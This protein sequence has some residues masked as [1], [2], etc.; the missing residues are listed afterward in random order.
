VPVITSWGRWPRYQQRLIALADRFAPPPDAASM[1]A[2]GNGRSYGDVCL[3]EGGT[4]LMT[5]ALDRFI[6]LDP[7][8]GIVECEAGTLLSEI[9]ELALPQGWFPPVSPGTALVTVGGAIANDVH[10]KN[11]HRTGSFGHHVLEFELQRSD[12]QILRCARDHHAQWFRATIGGLGLTGLIRK[13]RL[14][15]R[16]VAGPWMVGDSRRFNSLA[17]FFALAPQ[18]DRDHEYTVAWLD[19]ASAGAKLGRGVLMRANHTA[20]A[21]DDVP[22]G[23]AD[24]AATARPRAPRRMPFTPPVSLVNGL[25]VRVFNEL[26]FRRP[27]AHR[28]HALWRYQSFLYPLDAVLHWNRIYGPRGF[29]QYQC[30]LPGAEAE[31]VAALQDMLQRITAAGLG[32]FLAVLKKFGDMPSP[33]LLSFARPGVS[34]ALDFPNSGAATLRLLED[35]DAITRAMGGAVYPAKDARMSAASFQHYFPD[36]QQLRPFIDPRFSS[37]FWRRVTGSTT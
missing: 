34:L 27:A 22:A 20:N 26:Y 5:R 13:A 12:G 32:S 4:L 21:A 30:V 33:G 29:F 17:E 31:Q 35:L 11:H 2:Y 24:A 1:L 6:S 36:W 3:N 25:S 15:L 9:I 14:Q 10:G 7:A 18:S 37:S 19:C 28:A 8:A 16:R 23:A